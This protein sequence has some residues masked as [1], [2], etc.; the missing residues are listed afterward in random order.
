MH[1]V[2]LCCIFANAAG[3]EIGPRLSL[4]PARAGPSK[5]AM[6]WHKSARKFSQTGLKMSEL[7]VDSSYNLAIGSLIIGTTFGVLENNKGPIAKF[8]GAGALLFTIFAAFVAFQTT[9]LRFQFDDT[10]FSL[11]KFDG[12]KTGENVV[13]GG[14]NSWRYD[15]FVNYDYLPSKSFPILVYFKETQTPTADRVDAP[16]IVDNAVGQP[17][18]FPAIANVEQLDA[19]FKKHNCGKL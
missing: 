5:C 9:T 7:L 15:T 18:F 2:L 8:Y 14:A 13:V 4:I 10:T 1:L 3:F 12:Q 17:H 11:V 16:I 6:G 19:Q